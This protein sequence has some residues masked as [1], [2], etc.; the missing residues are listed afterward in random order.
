MSTT[1][2]TGEMS[3]I[4]KEEALFDMSDETNEP[5]QYYQYE[6][7]SLWTRYVHPILAPLVGYRMRDAY[8]VLAFLVTVSLANAFNMASSNKLL[9]LASCVIA[10]IGM[11]MALWE[12]PVFFR[13]WNGIS[14]SPRAQKYVVWMF[15]IAFSW[16]MAVAAG[17]FF[18]TTQSSNPRTTV[19]SISTVAPSTAP[20]V[21]PTTEE[22]ARP[23]AVPDA[24]LIVEDDIP[25]TTTDPVTTTPEVPTTTPAPEPTTPPEEDT[26]TPPI[27]D[28]D[29]PPPVQ[30]A[31]EDNT[32]P[33]EIIEPEPP[34]QDDP[35]VVIGPPSDGQPND[36]EVPQPGQ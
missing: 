22:A 30:Q 5:D 25:V 32:P 3:A 4:D 18:V 23:P 27:G 10:V 33:E 36:G 28:N 17:I 13:K 35:P 14:M 24:P 8:A 26:T 34:A 29:A 9:L 6:T 11:A 19:P 7:P 2:A 1:V 20:A 21:N 31:P 16:L 15:V 12:N